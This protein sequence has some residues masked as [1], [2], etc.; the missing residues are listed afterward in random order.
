MKFQ[1]KQFE[2]ASREIQ[3]KMPS[4]NAMPNAIG[5]AIVKLYSKC[6]WENIMEKIEFAIG[7]G[8][9]HCKTQFGLQ[10]AFRNA[11]GKLH[12]KKVVGHAG[13]KANCTMPLENAFGPFV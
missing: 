4:Q 9:W 6:G 10:N 12:F 2:D 3:R 1:K 8:K 11:V 5:N 13:G 7:I